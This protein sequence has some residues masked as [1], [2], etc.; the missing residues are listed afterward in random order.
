MNRRY[1]ELAANVAAQGNFYN[2]KHG[3][4]LVKGGSVINT[5]HNECVHSKLADRFKK[6]DGWGTRHAELNVCLGI[7][8]KVTN[9]SDIYVVRISKQGEPR[10]SKPCAMCMDTMKFVGVRRVYYSI[11]ETQY[12]V[13][14]LRNDRIRERNFGKEM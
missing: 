12:G 7:D 6:H 3:A 14:N 5:A 13:I 8:R 9:D 11:S 1:F 10:N 2:Y 4:V